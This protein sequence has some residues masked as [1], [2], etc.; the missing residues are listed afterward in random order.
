MKRV[1]KGHKP[2]PLQLESSYKECNGF[3]LFKI[4][5]KLINTQYSLVTIT[6]RKIRFTLNL[7]LIKVE[8]KYDHS[9]DANFDAHQMCVKSVIALPIHLILDKQ[10]GKCDLN[11]DST[12]DARQ[13]RNQICYGFATTFESCQRRGQT[14]QLL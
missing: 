9:F 7:I 10:E 5:S 3:S 8:V 12:F 6:A 2:K 14:C 4:W 1:A 11:F 13:R